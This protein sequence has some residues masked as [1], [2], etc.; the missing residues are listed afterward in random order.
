LIVP[1]VV[2]AAASGFV[3][4]VYFG[5]LWPNDLFAAAYP[6]RGIDVS[7]HQKTVDWV[8]VSRESGTDFAFLKATE[9]DDYR[10]R[11]FAT[12]WKSAREAGILRGAYHF[13]TTGSSG[14]EQA[15]NFI[16]VV[17][18]EPGSLPPVV[19]IET[20]GIAPEDF[21]RELQ[22][23]LDLVE[24]NYG[25]KPVL[26]T[27]YA[28]YDEYLKGGFEEYPLWIRDIVKPPAL[29]GVGD[30]LFWQYGNRGKVEGI[31]GYVDRNAFAGTRAELEALLSK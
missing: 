22:T 21:R 10:D 18:V 9:G 24:A 6:V 31:A 16:A 11:Y 2:L 12:N 19:D 13:F 26:Y 15:A 25:Q 20:G 5:I 28:L 1:A 14:A 23:Y 7:N 17:P 27:V 3:A 8:A 29:A 4:L 30:W